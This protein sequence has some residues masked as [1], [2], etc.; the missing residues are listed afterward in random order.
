[1]KRYCFN[2]IASVCQEST[3]IPNPRLAIRIRAILSC[4]TGTFA[5]KIR[6]ISR[7]M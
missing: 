6:L 2:Y 3:G 4:R 5:E 1:M 7:T